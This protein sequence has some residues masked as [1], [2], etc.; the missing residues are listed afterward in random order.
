MVPTKVGQTSWQLSGPMRH[1]LN[2][3]VSHGEAEPQFL[4]G[5]YE[6]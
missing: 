2:E 1:L 3:V 6:T 5:D 4:R